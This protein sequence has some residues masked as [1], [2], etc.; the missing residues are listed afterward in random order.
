MDLQCWQRT[1]LEPTRATHH[2]RFDTGTRLFISILTAMLCAAALVASQNT[3]AQNSEAMP[4]PDLDEYTVYSAVLNSKYASTKDEQIVINAETTSGPKRSF[5]SFRGAYVGPKRRPELESSTTSDFDEK[6]RTSWLL[7]K[8]LDLKLNY[9]LV[10]SDELRTTFRLDAH[11]LPNKRTW[12]EFYLHYP[13]SS[14][15]GSFSRVGF[16]AKHDQALV[17]IAVQHGLVGGSGR[18]C[19]LSRSDMMWKIQEEVL[20]WLS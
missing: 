4:I 12:E 11:G 10:T 6:N 16:N 18:F 5:I 14:G 17:Y 15:L 7:E 8:R 3:P 13:G 2:S 1:V 19:V 9:V 20:V